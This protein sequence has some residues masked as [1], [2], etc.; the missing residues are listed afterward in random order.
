MIS[1][2]RVRLYPAPTRCVQ[3]IAHGIYY[4]GLA[5]AA[6]TARARA[7][8]RAKRPSAGAGAGSDASKTQ[9]S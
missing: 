2:D 5:K 4:G 6:R 9:V 7:S 1:Y 8:A 3:E